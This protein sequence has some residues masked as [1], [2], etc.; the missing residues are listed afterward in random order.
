M[1]VL[2]IA[3][4]DLFHSLR[5]AFLLVMMF[6]AP[7]LITGLIYLAFGGLIDSG[8]GIKLP[9]SSVAGG[10]PRPA[11]A[12]VGVQGGRAAGPVPDRPGLRRAARATCRLADEA[13]AP[14]A[15]DT[16]QADVAVIIPA[17]FSCGCAGAAGGRLG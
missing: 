15:V 12:V 10:Q 1:K 3:L 17:E 14:A 6:V 2:D 5:S 13:A 16:H 7:L 8:G 11:F 4:K 9:R